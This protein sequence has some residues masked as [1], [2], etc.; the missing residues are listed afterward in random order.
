VKPE[1]AEYLAYARTMI[2][3][4][5]VMLG[6]SL[7]EEVGRAAY[8]ACFH[9]AQVLI[10]EQENRAVKTH[11]GVRSEFHRLTRGE[12]GLSDELRGFLTE[13]YGLKTAADY[14]P[15]GGM[16][17]SDED[18]RSVLETAVRFVDAVATLAARSSAQ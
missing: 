3:R 18:A 7:H 4:A 5:E 11:Q 9:A 14:D 6:V 17:S 1:T 15:R 8:M 12:A 10:F 2:G 13:A 16:L